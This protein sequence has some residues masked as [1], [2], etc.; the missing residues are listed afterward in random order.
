MREPTR[1]T[2][3]SQSVILFDFERARG[4]GEIGQMSLKS[5][6]IDLLRRLNDGYLVE[7]VE[8]R[9]IKIGKGQTSLTYTGRPPDILAMAITIG[10][11][12]RLSLPKQG[13]VLGEEV[14][15]AIV[16]LIRHFGTLI[17][18][19][20]R[21][22]NAELHLPNLLPAAER[23]LLL[24]IVTESSPEEIRG[25]VSSGLAERIYKEEL[26]RFLKN[27]ASGKRVIAT[28]LKP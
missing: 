27:T 10:F 1:T 15:R 11:C 14:S 20:S 25:I 9:A 4:D 26:H 5:A 21:D 7:S 2:H 16:S 22:E 17:V 8:V 6:L 24:A 12:S 19:L 28:T 18:S 23:I 13:L 3:P